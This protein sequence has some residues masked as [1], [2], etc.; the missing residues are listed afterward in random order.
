M[1]KYTDVTGTLAPEM[2][3]YRIAVPDIP[4]FTHERWARIDE[5]GWEADVFSMP[6]LAGTY[7]E[8]AKHHY[9]DAESIDQVTL[10]RLFVNATIL[11]IPKN[12]RE[13]IT[14]AEIEALNPMI[15]PGDA[16][17]VATGWDNLWWD[18]TGRFVNQSPHFERAAMEWITA[19]GAKIIGGDVPCFDDPVG[20]EADGVNTPLFE[21]G[22]LILAPLVN[23]TKIASQRVKLVVLPIKLRGS[24]GAP[25]RAIVIEEGDEA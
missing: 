11:Q 13:H 3:S 21:S 18:T 6:T 4:P 15:E 25:C 12:D 19:R 23:L 10:E 2:W 1:P 5:R 22:A 24:C 20:E 17:L 14:V 7:L 8:T 9:A 16:V